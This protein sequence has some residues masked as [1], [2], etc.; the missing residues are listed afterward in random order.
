MAAD[1]PPGDRWI[2]NEV[3]YPPG[4]TQFAVASNAFAN[5]HAEAIAE[6]LRVLW[7]PMQPDTNAVVTLWLSVEEPGHWRVRD[8]RPRPMD[9]QGNTWE[10]TVPVESV[11]IP[12]V[13]FVCAATLAATNLSPVR[14]CQPRGVGLE[15]PTR[16][17]WAFLEGFEQ[18]LHSWSLVTTA[19][20]VPV[21][22][23]SPTANT[24][25]AALLAAIPEG[26]HS[27]TL[28]TTRV[29]GGQ[30]EQHQA[31]GLR[32]WLRTRQGTG[33]VRFV[34]HANALTTN[35]V[36]AVFPSTFPV[37]DQWQGV[38]LPFSAF[39]R[40]PLRD[41]DWFTIEL[42]APSPREFLLD[43]LQYLGHWRPEP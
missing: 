38:D 12:V 9:L 25:F 6:N 32:L 22:R 35:Q 37:H 24:G 43:D 40:L 2:T 19:T 34:L 42:V 29:R 41:V 30:I 7:Q 1:R 5:L 4:C 15:I 3:L 28:G 21:L 31:T 13:Y 10:T 18:G 17:F 36:V 16:L 23:T 27:I 14:L 26:G 11:D 33:E 39:P 20:N 8:W